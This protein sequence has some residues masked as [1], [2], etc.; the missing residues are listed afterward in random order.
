MRI[1]KRHGSWGLDISYYGPDGKR[2][3]YSKSGFKTKR[4]AQQA[5][6]KLENQKTDHALTDEN[7]AFATAYLKWY[8]LYYSQN[9]TKNT[10]VRYLSIYKHL[11]AHFGSQKLK[12]ITRAKYQAF[13]NKYG[14]THSKSTV[15]K[16]SG[17]IKHFVQDSIADHLI[18]D[19]FTNRITLVWDASRTWQVEYLSVA[20]IKD[21]IKQAEYGL[22]PRYT[23]R[24]MILTGI[25]TGMR[26]GE[27][28][29]LTWDDID[30]DK[31]VISVKKSYQYATGK[32][33]DPK[34]PSSIRSIRVSANFLEIINQLRVNKKQFVFEN[35]RG[36]IPS[37]AACNKELRRLMKQAGI[38]KQGF[39]FH[40]LR[41]SHVA[42]LLYEG[43]PLFAISKRL[44]HANMSITA[45]KYA[46]LIDELKAKS[47]DKIEAIL[48]KL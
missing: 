41:H 2:H 27:I 34:T 37:S 40:S 25:Y 12:S 47:D 5:G 36:T 10:Q 16:T 26:I 13:M 29:A 3:W 39:H 33:K 6:F 42:L 48:K 8:K 15:Q 19:D 30:F 28:M 21:L 43:V 14:K 1:R 20:E 32:I 31:K 35:A 17:T 4:E 9:V 38:E 45:Q 44:G 18:T 7:P 22:D 46:Y 24:Y 11:R 23:S